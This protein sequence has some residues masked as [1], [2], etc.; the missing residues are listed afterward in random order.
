MF[1]LSAYWNEKFNMYSFCS[2]E[3]NTFVICPLVQ[4]SILSEQQN[5][6]KELIIFPLEF[7]KD[8]ENK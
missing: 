8:N 4:N 6:W 3:R 2:E 1:F 5:Y 7:L